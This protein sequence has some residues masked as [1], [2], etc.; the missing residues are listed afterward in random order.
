MAANYPAELMAAVFIYINVLHI[1]SADHQRV[2]QVLAKNLHAERGE[3]A[4]NK[5]TLMFLSC[6]HLSKNS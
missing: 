1:F 3:R 4:D 2:A 6:S 5:K